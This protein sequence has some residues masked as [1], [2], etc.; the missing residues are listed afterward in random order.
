MSRILYS[1]QYNP[2][3]GIGYF[4]LRTRVLCCSHYTFCIR[5]CQE[6]PAFT[7]YQK[8]FWDFVDSDSISHAKTTAKISSKNSAQTQKKH[9]PRGSMSAKTVLS[10]RDQGL[11]KVVP[12]KKPVKERSFVHHLGEWLKK[13]LKIYKGAIIDENTKHF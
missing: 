9:R 10:V 6:N 7:F 13:W 4:L 1:Y 8:C 2:P 3:F 5:L 11:E 12:P